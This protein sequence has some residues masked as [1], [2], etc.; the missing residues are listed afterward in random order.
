VFAYW[1][2]HGSALHAGELGV[3]FGMGANASDERVSQA[4]KDAWTRF[5]ITGDPNGEGETLWPRFE[6]STEQ[7]LVLA[8][9]LH[10]EAHLLERECDLW[11]SLEP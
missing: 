9:P 7:Q 4:I 1:F 8:D 11:D 5:A 3:L 6:A 10:V 2:A